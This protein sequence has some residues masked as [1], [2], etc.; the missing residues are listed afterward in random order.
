MAIPKVIYQTFKTNRIP[1]L[2][3]YY[4]WRFL[5]KNK[6]YRREFFDDEQVDAFIKANF[7]D[8]IYDAYSRLQIGAAKADFFR[9][10]ILYKN[11]GIYLDLDSD[12]T[13][14]F[15]DLLRDDDVAVIVH[16]GNFQQFYSQ[17]ALI[18]DKNHPF[19]EETIRL[20]VENIEGNRFPHDVHQMTGPAVYAKAINNVLRRDPTVRHRVFA[21]D[22]KGLM[23]FKYKLGKIL[24]YGDRS[25]HWKNMQKVVP[26]VRPLNKD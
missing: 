3:K 12:I 11:G 21:D 10:A 14:R 24:I 1:F 13:G 26:V 22:Y 9:Y 6:E 2:T 17:W 23:K 20:I 25:K 5:K 18:F 16:E 4:I 8:R 15:D 7:N 19:L